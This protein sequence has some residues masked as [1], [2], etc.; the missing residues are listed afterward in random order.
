MELAQGVT[1]PELIQPV[2]SRGWLE[3]IQP[4]WNNGGKNNNNQP[5]WEWFIPPIYGDLGDGWGWFMALFYNVLATLISKA[6]GVE[7][8]AGSVWSRHAA[9]VFEAPCL[10]LEPRWSPAICNV[11]IFQEENMGHGHSGIPQ[12][13]KLE[14]AEGDVLFHVISQWEIHLFWESIRI[15]SSFF[16]AE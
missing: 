11:G 8:P 7:R 6:P 9:V 1:W 2:W 10:Q 14:K 15:T 4:M 3:T 12:H 16:G 13:E 5:I